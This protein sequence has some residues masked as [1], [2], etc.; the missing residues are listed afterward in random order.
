[1][2]AGFAFMEKEKCGYLVSPNLEDELVT[3]V[4]FG[5]YFSLFLMGLR[6]RLV[7]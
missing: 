5:F 3:S 1:M 2:L 4:V 7:D 6:C